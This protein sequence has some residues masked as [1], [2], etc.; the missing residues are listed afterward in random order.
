MDCNKCKP[1]YLY[2][3][4]VSNFLYTE[5]LGIV[6]VF[7]NQVLELNRIVLENLQNESKVSYFFSIDCILLNCAVRTCMEYRESM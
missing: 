7:S 1:N 2:L 4:H 5:L 3:D 6:D